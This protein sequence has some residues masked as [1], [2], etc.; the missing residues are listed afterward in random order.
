MSGEV[1]EEVEFDGDIFDQML[2][3]SFEESSEKDE[4]DLEEEDEAE[5]EDDA[6]TAE[7]LEDDEYQEDTDQDEESEDDEELDEDGDGD[8][9]ESSEDL[10]DDEEEDSLVDD[11]SLDDEDSDVEGSG[12][13]DSED[14]NDDAA[15]DE[16]TDDESEDETE[17][18]DDGIEPESKTTDEIDY[19]SFYDSVVNTEFIVNGK[20]TKGFSDP[21]KIIQSQQMAGGFSEKMAG[22]KQYRPFMTPLKD[23]GMLDDQAK[24]DLAMNLVDGDKEAIKQHLKTLNID[25][26][27]LDMEEIHYDAK[28][29]VASPEALA[30]EDALERARI[31]GIEDRVR[32]VIGQ[33][34]DPD[35]F[36]EFTS[37]PQVRNDLLTHI[38]TGVYDT[39]QD[40]ISELK[41]VDYSGAYSSLST[42]NQYRAAVGELQKEQAAN[43]AVTEQPATSQPKATKVAKKSSVASE[44]AKIA[45]ARQEEKYKEDAA[46]REAQI[47]KKRKRAASVSKKKPKAKPKPKFDPMAVEGEDLDNLMAQLISGGR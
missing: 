18:E 5:V 15:A 37:N 36:Q 32:K 31:S 13:E 24:F 3:G 8:L 44:K 29:N 27:E 16:D 38:E 46:K 17:T 7:D 4:P 25:P 1:K 28:S 22:F 21:K 10:D 20:K 2:G 39:V 43:P 34:W 35:S 45:K 6:D 12:D 33:E 47:N 9:D 40:K 42:I 19:K 30:V 26:L 14:E 41:R 23:R 11:G